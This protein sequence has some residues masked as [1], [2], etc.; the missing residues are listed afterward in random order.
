MIPSEPLLAI[1]PEVELWKEL[2]CVLVGACSLLEYS[3]SRSKADASLAARGTLTARS[4][5]LELGSKVR[6][7]VGALVASDKLLFCSDSNF[8]LTSPHVLCVNFKMAAK[9]F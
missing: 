1:L 8:H 9:T 3:S 4:S 7:R 6:R 5:N 2:A